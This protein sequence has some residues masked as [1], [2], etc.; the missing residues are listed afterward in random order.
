L[1]KHLLPTVGG[2]RSAVAALAPGAVA[3]QGHVL[4]TGD[5]LTTWAVEL[6]V[7]TLDLHREPTAAGLR[8]ARLTVEALVPGE[9]PG[10][11]ADDTVVLLGTGRAEPEPG[12]PWAAKLPVF[13]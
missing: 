9:L 10:E 4:A 7:H 8:L 6:A 3:F 12:S 5:F 13:G 2:I 11:W 1:V